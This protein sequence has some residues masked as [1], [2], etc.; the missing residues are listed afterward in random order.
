LMPFDFNGF[1]HS[2]I[3]LKMSQWANR[4]RYFYLT[5]FGSKM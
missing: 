4:P 5:P 1:G 3:L 2:D